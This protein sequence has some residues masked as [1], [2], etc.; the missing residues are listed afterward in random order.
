MN[1]YFDLYNNWININ[2]INILIYIIGIGP[3]FYSWEITLHL[4]GN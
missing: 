4:L 2:I 3:F 1:K